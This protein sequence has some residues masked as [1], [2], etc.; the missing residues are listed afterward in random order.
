[1]GTV[2]MDNPTVKDAVLLK[3]QLSPPFV[4]RE[5]QCAPRTSKTWYRMQTCIAL[6]GRMNVGEELVLQNPNP[7]YHKPHAPVKRASK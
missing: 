7:E 5:Q 6:R 3:R 1:M 4:M 2:C